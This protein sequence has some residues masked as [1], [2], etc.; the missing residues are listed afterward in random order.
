VLND[1]NSNNLYIIQLYT[2]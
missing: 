1:L 2:I